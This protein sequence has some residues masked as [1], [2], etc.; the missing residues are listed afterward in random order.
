MPLSKPKPVRPLGKNKGKS[1]RPNAR[2]GFTT[3]V[4]SMPSR[5]IN[6][7]PFINNMAHRE[8][9]F[10]V[11][12]STVETVRVQQR[13]NPRNSTLFPWLSGLANNF[14]LFYFTNLSF[15]WVPFCPTSTAGEVVMAIDY[16]VTDP[17]PQ[18]T[19]RLGSYAGA[20]SS[21]IY[22]PSTCVFRNESTLMK[23]HKYFCSAVDDTDRF[24]S[25]GKFYLMD[26]SGT[27]IANAGVLW[28]NYVVSLFNP[29]PYVTQVAASMLLKNTV[30]NGNTTTPL[31]LWDTSTL[32]GQG[33][34]DTF[35]QVKN[36][37]DPILAAAGN[38]NTK[39]LDFMA[40]RRNLF[41]DTTFLDVFSGMTKINTVLHD[42]IPSTCVMVKLNSELY[43]YFKVT[44]T[45]RGLFTPSENGN[46]A[47][48]YWFA[49][50]GAVITSHGWTT[51]TD[52]G[53]ALVKST[54]VW[55]Y[56]T[57]EAYFMFPNKP[58]ILSFALD[59]AHGVWEQGSGHMEIGCGNNLISL[60]P[61]F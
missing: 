49:T 60:E 59:S 11:S 7:P 25:P 42:D 19:T 10:N 38:V 27:D 9:V 44:I 28:V 56:M 39:T 12:S 29:E 18:T 61:V 20:I 2:A 15:E 50:S 40:Y 48:P 55:C 51:Q 6:N 41:G 26:R 58:Y 37:V 54:P 32:V 23:N 5:R 22:M 8:K 43:N 31:G 36:I 4:V 45:A 14:D 46:N 17:A 52:D 3:G 33:V 21:Q 16:D 1:A 30:A 24:N 34:G 53:V 35:Y 57:H 13:I 47:R